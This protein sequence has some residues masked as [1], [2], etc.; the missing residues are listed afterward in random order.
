MFRLN[1]K[2]AFR[3]LWKNKGYA[4]INILGLS[5]G[6][7]SCI[8]IFIFIRHQLSFDSSYKNNDRIYRFVTNWKYNSFKD[9]SQ[10]VPVPLANA[11]RN[12]FAAF[13]KVAPITKAAM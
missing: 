1:F 4:F 8:L 6:M 5:I 3:N 11:A 10:G 12:E 7:M 9:Y 2:I 13:E